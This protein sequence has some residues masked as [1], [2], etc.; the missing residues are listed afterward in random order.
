M[1][2][3]IYNLETSAL[4]L[5]VEPYA[6]RVGIILSNS[7]FSVGAGP[8]LIDYEKIMKEANLKTKMHVLTDQYQKESTWKEIEEAFRVYKLL[9]K[10][11]G[12]RKE[13]ILFK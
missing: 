8:F 1:N 11:K 10:K 3:V 5:S 4:D 13:D 12:I 2:T 9:C 6:L 7:A